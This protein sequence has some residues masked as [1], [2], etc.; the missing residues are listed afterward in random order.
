MDKVP[1]KLPRCR[2]KIHTDPMQISATSIDNR[3]E[4]I[5]NASMSANT[6]KSYSSALDIFKNFRV[7]QCRQATWPPNVNE[8]MDFIAYLSITGCAPSTIKS[9]ISAIS[10]YCKINNLYDAT[11]QFVV[12]KMLAGVSRLD[13][14]KDLRMPITYA[15][16]CKIVNS[17][18][19]VC[20]SYFEISLFVAIFT[21]AF[22]GFMRVGELVANC[23]MDHGH[24]LLVS[25]IRYVGSNN[26]LEIRIAHSKTDQMGTGT[27]IALPAVNASVCPVKAFQSYNQ[28]IPHFQGL[29]FRHVD[30]S[31]VTRYQFSSVLATSL[32]VAGIDN[33]LYKS[34]SFRIGAASSMAM[35]GMQGE[36]VAKYGRWQSNA[37]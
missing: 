7:Q 19:M 18:P 22:Y 34:H 13:V 3:I 9:Y 29:Y 8:I 17:L 30:F 25:N 37:Y 32:K 6:A 14:R 36:N 4:Q 27:I 5:L 26:T 11:Q 10:Y 24:A 28:I 33:K 16:L 1:E 31:V 12:R 35:L 21:I 15:I 2:R 20:S 23:K